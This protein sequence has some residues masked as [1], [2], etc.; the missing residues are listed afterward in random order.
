MIEDTDQLED[1]V[2]D[3]DDDLMLTTLDNPYNPKEDYG[4][5]KRWDEDNN[6]YTESYIARLIDMEE[7]VDDDD[8][9]LEELRKKV[10]LD[11]LEHDVLNVYT[12]V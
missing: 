5:W 3:D 6:Y 2:L 1:E 4:K 11:I 10:I 9:R 12:L 7:F 8:L